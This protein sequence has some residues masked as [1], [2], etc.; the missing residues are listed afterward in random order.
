MFV[1]SPRS[2]LSLRDWLRWPLVGVALPTGAAVAGY[3]AYLW[4]EWGRNPDLSHGF[5]APLVFALLV[6]EGT[7]LGAQRWLAASRWTAVVIGLL[8]VAALASS[9]R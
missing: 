6:W 3:C 1:S 2:A 7:R 4:P 9:T 8:V 5:F